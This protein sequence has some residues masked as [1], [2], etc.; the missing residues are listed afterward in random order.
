MPSPTTMPLTSIARFAG[1]WRAH[2]PR[3]FHFA[4]TSPSWLN[5]VDGYFAT[6]TK[7]R[8]K[9]SVFRSRQ[10]RRRCR[11]VRHRVSVSCV[12]FSAAPCPTAVRP[13]RLLSTAWPTRSKQTFP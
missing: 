6:L 2:P 9:R 8:L 13:L 5:A 7:R 12:M 1:G 3:A 4:S 10:S 11:C